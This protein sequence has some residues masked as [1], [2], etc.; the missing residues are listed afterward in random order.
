[1]ITYNPDTLTDYFL[2]ACT[3]GC[4]D[5]LAPTGD[6]FVII[7]PSHVADYPELVSVFGAQIT[8]TNRLVLHGTRAEYVGAISNAQTL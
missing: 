7:R 8:P 3:W 6:E 2:D 1:M 5:L 4:T